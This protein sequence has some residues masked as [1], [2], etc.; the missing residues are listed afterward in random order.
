MKKLMLASVIGSVC[1]LGTANAHEDK[2]HLTFSSDHCSIN[3]NYGVVVENDTIRF[4]DNDNTIVQINNQKDLFVKGKQIDLTDDQQALVSDYAS[5]VN[6]QI[7]KVVNI[8]LDA[9]EIAF[10]ALSHV[11]TGLTGEDSSSAESLNQSFAKIKEKV[12]TRFHAE[13]GSVYLAEQDFDDIDQFIED[14]LEGEIEN[15][16]VNS[17]GDILIAVG[18]AMNDEEGDFEQ[19]ME[20]FGERMERMGEEIEVAVE[21]QAEELGAQAETLCADLHDLNELED[22]LTSNVDALADFNLIEVE[23]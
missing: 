14:E 18:Q 21:D 20:A 10:S 4:L 23:D 7:P 11:A 2:D 9:V 13:D 16:V 5:G 22:E 12:S 1:L 19:K 3:M 17:V 8:A 6:Q 15:L